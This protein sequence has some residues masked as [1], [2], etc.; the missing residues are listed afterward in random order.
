MNLLMLKTSLDYLHNDL[1]HVFPAFSY[2]FFIWKPILVLI[3]FLYRMNWI[4]VHLIPFSLG[5]E[6]T[7][8]LN[9]WSFSDSC[10][11]VLYKGLPNTFHFTSHIIIFNL[12]LSTL[13]NTYLFR[14]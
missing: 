5:F 9:Y 14:S 3:K 4:Y 6:A 13:Q 7:T 10:S 11:I 8:F 1:M 12:L 2:I